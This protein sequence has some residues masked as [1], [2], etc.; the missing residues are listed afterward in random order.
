MCLPPIT[1]RFADYLAENAAKMRLVAKAAG[2]RDL[3]LRIASGFHHFTCSHDPPPRDKSEGRQACSRLERSKELA[4][5][6]PGHRCQ[7]R[8]LYARCQI[9]VEYSVTRFNCQGARPPRCAPGFANDIGIC[10]ETETVSRADARVRYCL[11]S[12][13]SVSINAA[14]LAIRRTTCGSGCRTRCAR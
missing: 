13:R 10:L 6:E 5:A 9:G 11:A 7:I 1:W 3:A 4:D 12:S 8:G 2:D 14:A